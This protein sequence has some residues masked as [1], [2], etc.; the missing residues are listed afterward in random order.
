MH[1]QTIQRIL[2]GFLILFLFSANML[3]QRPMEKLGRGLVAR[4]VGNNIHV[5]WRITSEEWY[6]TSY[7][8][9][10]D[11]TLIYESGTD[12]AS[13]YLDKSG[14][15][16]SVYTIKTV[17]NGV[18][19]SDAATQ[20]IPTLTRDYHEIP[21][22]TFE[23]SHLYEP[24]DATVAD[25]DG[26]GE[27]EIIIKRIYANWEVN[28]PYYSY[29]EAYKLDGTFMWAIDAG[30]NI[31]DDVEINIAAYDFD[32]DGKAEVFMRTSEGTVFG[33]GTAIGDVNNDG[34][35]NYRTGGQYQTTCPEYLSLID[36]ETGAELDRVEFIPRGRHSDWGAD[37]GG[38]R[39]SKYFFGA[40]FLD[41]EKPSLF[42]GRG[43]YGKTVMRTYDV[44]NKKM[45]LR[46]E[47]NSENYSGYSGQGNHANMI[48]DVDG[49]GRDEIVWGSMTV[50][51]NGKGLYTTWLGHGDAM[52]IGDFDPYHKGIEI[53][54][55]HEG[56]T[57]VSLREGATGK[58]LIRRWTGRDTGRCMAAVVG[59]PSFKGA[60]LGGGPE[61][62]SATSRQPEVGKPGLTNNFRTYWDGDLWEEG[63]DYTSFSSSTGGGEGGIFKWGYSSPIF[64]TSGALTNNWTIGTPCVQVDMLGDWRE[65]FVMRSADNKSLRIYMTPSATTHRV[66]TLMHDP[67][68]RQAIV[69]QMCGYNQPPH[70]G[71]YIGN[72][73]PTPIPSK[74]TNG[75]LVW[76][77]TN[78]NW[79]KI[80]TNFVDGDDAV[81]LIKGTGTP[82]AFADGDHV[83][84]D[85]RGNQKNIQIT[86]NISP[87]L[88]MVSGTVD[89]EI[90]GTGSLSGDMRLDKLGEGSLTLKGEHSYSGITD[91]WEGYLQADAILN[92]SLVIVRR[93]A[94]FGGAGTF[95]QG[96]KTEYNGSI[97]V[98]GK[99]KV[100]VTTVKDSINLVEGAH[101]VFDL[102]E[103]IATGNDFLQLDGKLNIENNS[104]ITIN[105]LSELAY[106][107][108]VIASID[109]LNGDLTK[110]RIDGISGVAAALN[111]D[112]T[113]KELQ[114]LVKSIRT[115]TRIS[116]S[117]AESQVWDLAGDLNW[118]NNGVDDY[119]VT[120]DSVFFDQASGRRTLN[121]PSEIMPGYVEF[122]STEDYVIDDSS[123]PLTGNMDLV[124]KNT[125]KLTIN[126]KNSYTGKTIVEGGA[127]ILKYLP[128]SSEDGGIGANTK[129]AS[130][131]E[132]KNGAELQ[133]SSDNQMTDIGV[134]VS[135]DEGGVFNITRDVYW[136][137]EIKGTKFI[138]TGAGRLYI[139]Y[140]NQNLSEVELNAGVIELYHSNPLHGVGKKITI[141]G[142]TLL[143]GGGSGEYLSTALNFHVPQGRA[144]TVYASPR[145]E[146]TGTLT[147]GGTLNWKADFIRS[148]L[149]GNWSAFEGNI[150]V[151]NSGFNTQYGTHFIF[152]NTYGIPNATL[153]LGTDVWMWGA[154]T[155][156]IGMLTGVSSATIDGSFLEIGGNNKNGT[157]NGVI[158][159]SASVKKVGTGNWSVTGAHTYTG[160]TN[161]SEGTM[162]INGSLGASNI[163]ITNVGTMTIN[164]G[165]SVGGT[166][167]IQGGGTLNCNGTAGRT[168]INLGTLRGYGRITG[169]ATLGMNS[170][171]APGTASVLGTLNFDGNATMNNV[172][173]TL[174]I[175]VMGSNTRS[176][177]L[178]VAGTLTCKGNLNVTV[179][180][181][182]LAEGDSYNIFSAK[183]IAGTFDV[184]NLPELESG[185]EWDIS[186]LYTEGIISVVESTGI[187]LPV[188]NTALLG[189]PTTGIFRVAVES[190]EDLSISVVDLL[191]KVIYQAEASPVSGV[192]EVNITDR[193]AGSY[194]LRLTAKG[195]QTAT[196][197]LMKL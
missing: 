193:P 103:D 70:L 178:N 165:R 98:G 157:Y 22:R 14:T 32:G 99:G 86:E 96:I 95:H 118:K 25:L 50:D 174:E 116:W 130:M 162:I 171:T 160:A 75:K 110:V 62:Y 34:R 21:L 72:D 114:L 3:A 143:C 73:F 55:C 176:D 184:I 36:G 188:L 35:I 65:E 93:H 121:I 83:L 8:L 54:A 26:D 194:V 117:G 123:E 161:V 40:P 155:I 151:T 182:T 154:S 48:A 49:D 126:N 119:F 74:T 127:L 177:K 124:K 172:S 47:F 97:F 147:G 38:H 135:G 29:F 10:R 192:I 77:G 190:S 131:L 88:L 61:L 120:G 69:W 92:N 15:V 37:D 80:A 104:T 173:S 133:V 137:G 101:L 56:A 150:N 129:D 87:A 7:N 18:E 12:G 186:Q 89:Y 45:I 59:D 60:A 4:K 183:S 78:G 39:C 2:G 28:A 6:N 82:T 44:V 166:V 168:V 108:Y 42:T 100:G 43:I 141:N 189:N 102:S 125:G 52:H 167:T 9:Y 106:G 51:D 163:T 64:T 138:K 146:Y 122:N 169:N 185:L 152:D 17:V 53:W 81:S 33:D 170:V 145:C 139:G 158:S 159:G 153:N 142:G 11:G 113:S 41:G 195:Q 107:T 115:P 68:Y 112:Q 20:V 156:K 71:Y 140:Q 84:F 23:G 128:S 191:G 187:H 196:L 164:S 57:G 16:S 179:H 5:N 148:Y 144:G 149:K 175:R 134:T 79:N 85:T 24:N 13:S 180:S 94:E 109:E 27:Y 63:F 111:Y 30:P 66:Y 105:R 1:R 91:V 136:N 197:M 90:G 181:G 67:Q 76:K 132:L 58:V 19:S 31:T 46:W